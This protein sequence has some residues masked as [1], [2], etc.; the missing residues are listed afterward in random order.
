MP[1]TV[2]NDLVEQM[3]VVLEKSFNLELFVKI[4]QLHVL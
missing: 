1:P 4:V 2:H 3:H